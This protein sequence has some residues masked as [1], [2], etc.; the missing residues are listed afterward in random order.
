MY[1]KLNTFKADLYNVFVQ[2]N[3]SSIQMGRVFLVLVVPVMAIFI[4]GLHSIKY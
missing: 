1:H 3:A 4:V 2:G